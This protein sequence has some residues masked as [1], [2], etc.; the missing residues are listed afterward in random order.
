[1][2]HKGTDIEERERILLLGGFVTEKGR[3][4]G[5]L[6]VARSLGDIASAPFVTSKPYVNEIELT[7]EDEFLVIGCD[8]VYDV[9]TDQEVVNL[10][11][12]VPSDN[13]ATILRD[14]A[15]LNGS[16]DNISAIVVHLKK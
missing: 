12:K 10:V 2:D 15:Y 1:M 9:F 13:A 11:K 8:G 6:A 4:V 5:D 16:N 3:V 14:Y 7:D